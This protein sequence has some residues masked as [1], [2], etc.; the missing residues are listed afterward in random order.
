MRE[1][2]EGEARDEEERSPDEGDSP[3]HG[4]KDGC[5]KKNFERQVEERDRRK[6]RGDLLMFLS[7][8]GGRI[9]TADEKRKQQ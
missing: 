1:I 5:K 9:E 7:A 4:I 8:G 2:C 6:V 3:H